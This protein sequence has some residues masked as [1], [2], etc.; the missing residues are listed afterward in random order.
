MAR[1]ARKIPTYVIGPDGGPLTLSDLPTPGTKRWVCRRKAEV[2]AAVDGGL[3]SLDEA[4]RRYSLSI[5]EFI[6]WQRAFDRFGQ[7]GLR[8]T[9]SR[10]KLKVTDLRVVGK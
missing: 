5:E 4:C 7:R 3:L 2:V 10:P 6:A 8:A 1:E 9:G